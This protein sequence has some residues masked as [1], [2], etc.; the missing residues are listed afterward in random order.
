ML[1]L[2]DIN[3]LIYLKVTFVS[4]MKIKFQYFFIVNWKLLPIF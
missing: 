4:V 3:T 2:M 1:Y